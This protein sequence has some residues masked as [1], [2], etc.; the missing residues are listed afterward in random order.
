M[1]VLSPFLSIMNAASNQEIRFAGCIVPLICNRALAK[2]KKKE[3]NK[4]H[5]LFLSFS[6]TVG[7]VTNPCTCNFRLVLIVEFNLKAV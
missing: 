4:K 2:K 6:N 3:K 5:L 1:C 7:L